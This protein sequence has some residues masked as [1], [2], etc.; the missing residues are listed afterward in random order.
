MEEL[1]DE[2]IARNVLAIAAVTATARRRFWCAVRFDA[3]AL[4]AVA[5]VVV[6]CAIVEVRHVDL[7][8]FAVAGGLVAPLI[9]VV[10]VAGEALVRRRGLGCG[11]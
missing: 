8:E 5:T 6:P 11:L 3:A 9:L 4:V 7:D 1:L 2:G 10:R